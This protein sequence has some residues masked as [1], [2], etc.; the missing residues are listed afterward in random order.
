MRQ[1]SRLLLSILMVLSLTTGQA[2]AEDSPS[3]LDT[4]GSLTLTRPGM[5]IAYRGTVRNSDYQFRVTIPPE[6]TGWS[7]VAPEAPFHGFVV[8]L[9]GEPIACINFE[10]HIR[11]DDVAEGKG[12]EKEQ[13]NNMVKVGNIT[14]R[15]ERTSG[16]IDG[17]EWANVKIKFSVPQGKRVDDG[18]VA[19]ITPV[20]D[21]N[22]NMPIFQEFISKIQFENTAKRGRRGRN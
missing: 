2:K 10:M 12:Q 15:E 17:I 20:R 3:Q 1:V 18:S 7:G 5:G 14:G 9:P 8:F 22:R 6:L 4:C 13:T 19:L 21:L 16:M 11:I